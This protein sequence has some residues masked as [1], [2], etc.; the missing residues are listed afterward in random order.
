MA[1]DERRRSELVTALGAVR[2]RISDACVSAGRDARDVTLIAVTKTYPA[3]DIAT[4]RDLGVLDIGESKD[5]EAR[6]KLSELATLSGSGEVRWHFVGRV[7]S[8]K[9]AR[10]ASYAH[11][12]HSVDR[13]ELVVAFARALDSDGSARPADGRL[14]IFV[15]LSLDGDPDRSGAVGDD[16]F[17]LADEVA[18]VPSLRLLGVM[19]VPPVEA[20]PDEAF[21]R[22][23][24][25]SIR[26][27]S[28]HPDAASISAG[29]SSDLEPAIKHGATH[30]RVGTALLGRR[31][32][33]FS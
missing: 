23:A 2:V 18:A 15:Q 16:L 14:G 21:A 11:A 27:R 17:R 22:I 33:F 24:E 31:E 9:A 25:V 7:Q 13:R 19:A 10:V 5:Q 3:S 8:K 30:V 4:L 28:M 29:M 20:V 6:A 32:A 12:V 1:S 26:L